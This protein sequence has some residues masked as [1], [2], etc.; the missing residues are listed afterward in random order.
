MMQK[1]KVISF[2][3]TE[4]MFSKLKYIAQKKGVT[5]TDLIRY[6]IQKF[7]E[8]EEKKI[9]KPKDFLFKHETVN[10][11][12]NCLLTKEQLEDFLLNMNIVGVV[13]DNEEEDFLGNEIFARCLWYAHTRYPDAKLEDKVSFSSLITYFVTGLDFTCDYDNDKKKEAEKIIMQLIGGK[14]DENT[15]MGYIPYKI[16]AKGLS[17][18][19]TEKC[20]RQLEIFFFTN[21]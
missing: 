3:L 17:E 1:E 21:S 20:F 16:L 11:I 12:I 15:G 13:I 9:I 8:E 2:R 6:A 10:K 5:Y 14:F 19:E 18:K 7:V 4:K